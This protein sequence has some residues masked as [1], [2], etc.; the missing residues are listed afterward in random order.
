MA[1]DEYEAFLRYLFDRH[2]R[3]RLPDAYLSRRQFPMENEVAWALSNLRE[4]HRL[5]SFIQG[6]GLDVARIYET[7][8]PQALALVIHQAEMGCGS[9]TGRPRRWA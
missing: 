6:S 8:R 5:L 3:E 4:A 9:T 2:V 7:F 1:E